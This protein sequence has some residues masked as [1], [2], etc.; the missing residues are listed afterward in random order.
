M[1]LSI[2]RN[3]YTCIKAQVESDNLYLIGFGDLHAGSATYNEKKTKEIIQFIK[4]NNCVVL[5]MG[6]LAENANKKSIG[7]GV[8]NQKMIPDEQ[9]KYLRN[10]LEPIKDKCIGMIKGNHEE[11][12]YKDSGI[13]ICNILSY[14]LNIPYCWWEF[15]GS[16]VGD[17]RGYSIYAVHSY[18][19]NKR[20]GAAIDQTMRD[21]EQMVDVDIIMRGHTHKNIA[22][23]PET[24]EVD[25]RNNCVIEK[26]RAIVITGHFLNRDKS[27]AA[28]KPLRGDP[29]GTT[30]L[31]LEM[32]K[33]KS[34][35]IKRIY[36]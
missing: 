14:E 7:A 35:N 21:I 4:E 29:P 33:H 1:N 22:H 8:Y 13:D 27:Y 23:L 36:L 2:N 19:S 25:M 6:D 18:T 15:F 24:Y 11:R 17:K 31:E 12:T 10:L 9:I 5:L 16:I 20:A 32:N 28:A 26:K 3:G 34:K 30:A